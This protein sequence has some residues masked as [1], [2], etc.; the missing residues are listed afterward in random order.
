ML[1]LVRSAHIVVACRLSK[2]LGSFP[3]ATF[4]TSHL[5][6]LQ[7]G[8]SHFCTLTGQVALYNCVSGTAKHGEAGSRPPIHPK[9]SIVVSCSEL[10]V[11]E[12]DDEKGIG[13]SGP[14]SFIDK[15][16]P[17]VD[18]SSAAAFTGFGAGAVA[19]PLS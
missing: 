8:A 13:S 7:E 10:R 9:V 1:S 6:P 12:M 14:E 2:V 15:E 5:F 19:T 11:L 18:A 3:I 4:G 16:F 17:T